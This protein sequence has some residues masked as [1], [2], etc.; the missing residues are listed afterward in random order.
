MRIAKAITSVFE[1]LKGFSFFFF[2]T[3]GAQMD[4]QEATTDSVLPTVLG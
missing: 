2:F 3:S 4:L 1:R